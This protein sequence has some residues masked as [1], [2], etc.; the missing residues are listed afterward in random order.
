MAAVQAGGDRQGGPELG[1]PH[2]PAGTPPGE[3]GSGPPPGVFDRVEGGP[4]VAAGGFATELDP[5]KFGGRGPGQGGRVIA[6]HVEPIRRRY[7]GA[8]GT[9]ADLHV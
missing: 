3:G 6:G 5:Q 2:S 4:A 8:L 1:G 9:K 7:A